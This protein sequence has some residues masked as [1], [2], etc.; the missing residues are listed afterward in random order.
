M[1]Q[2]KLQLL[3]DRMEIIDTINRYA[4]SVDTRDWDLFLTCYTDEMIA[5]MVSVGF[6]EPMDHVGKGVS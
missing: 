3:Y 5:D 1:D 4:T 6:D 2:K